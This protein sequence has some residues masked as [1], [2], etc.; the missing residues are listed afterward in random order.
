MSYNYS[1]KS[2][3]SGNGTPSHCVGGGVGVGEYMVRLRLG[4]EDAEEDR[5]SVTYSEK[6][7][8]TKSIMRVR[9]FQT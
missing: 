9:D 6:Y 7:C 1:A 4:T 3:Y 5:N 2:L 8:K